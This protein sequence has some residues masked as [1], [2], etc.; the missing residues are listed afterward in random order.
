[1]EMGGEGMRD[2]LRWAMLAAALLGLLLAGVLLHERPQ[3]PP[4]AVDSAALGLLLLD[5]EEGVYVLAVSERSL[6]DQAGL[7]PGDCILCAGD[8]ALGEAT[9]LNRLLEQGQES[10]PL[11]VRRE[12]NVIRLDLPCR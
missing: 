8:E 11:T 7:L 2:K 10:L 3:D 9:G 12:D 6:A 4:R 5:A 1:M